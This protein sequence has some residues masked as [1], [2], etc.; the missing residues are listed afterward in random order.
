MALCCVNHIMVK[1]NVHQRIFPIAVATEF[2]AFSLM[3]ALT[4]SSELAAVNA[5]EGSNPAA[6]TRPVSKNDILWTTMR[7]ATRIPP[8]AAPNEAKKKDK[9]LG[10]DNAIRFNA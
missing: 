1:I 2:A 5:A 9:F 6:L 3:Y 7:K 4:C 10:D 8:T